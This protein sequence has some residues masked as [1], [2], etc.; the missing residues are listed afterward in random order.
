MKKILLAIGL[1]S[2]SIPSWAQKNT[3]RQVE[4]ETKFLEVNKHFLQDIGVEFGLPVGDLHK[5]YSFGIGANYTGNYLVNKTFAISGDASY[6]Y[7]FGKT[8]S[9]PVTSYKYPGT[10][11]INILAG[12]RL[13]ILPNTTV[14]GRIGLSVELVNGDSGTSF[15]WQGELAHMFP[16]ALGKI[17]ILGSMFRF[18]SSGKSSDRLELGIFITPHIIHPSE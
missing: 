9:G 17:P 13:V 7:L 1:F 4:I 6:M 11:E 2:F 18:T 16:S 5:G 14:S 15:A 8:V 3:S 10:S 12:P